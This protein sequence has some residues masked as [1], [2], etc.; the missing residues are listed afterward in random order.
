MELAN[1]VYK[2]TPDSKNKN[3]YYFQKKSYQKTC[4]IKNKMLSL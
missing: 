3:N 1:G 2:N 4:R